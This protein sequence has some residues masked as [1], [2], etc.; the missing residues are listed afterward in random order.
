MKHPRSFRYNRKNYLSNFNEWLRINDDFSKSKILLPLFQHFN[1]YYGI[2]VDV[3]Q[4]HFSKMMCQSYD[5]D[6]AR[7]KK[8]FFEFSFYVALIKHFFSLT[9]LLINY[10]I[11]K[12]KRS[13]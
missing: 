4:R 3:S 11:Q 9:Y 12:N 1:K 5:F 7:F 13:A 8:D 10:K 2:D 6:H